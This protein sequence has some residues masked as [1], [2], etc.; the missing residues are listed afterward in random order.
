[1]ASWLK[2]VIARITGKSAQKFQLTRARA[3]FTHGAGSFDMEYPTNYPMDRYMNPDM[4]NGLIARL[5]SDG[6]FY[7]ERGSGKHSIDAELTVTGKPAAS[8]YELIKDKE[9]TSDG[10]AR[11]G[12]FTITFDEPEDGENNPFQYWVEVE[13][14]K[15]V[16]T[17]NRLTIEYVDPTYYMVFDQEADMTENLDEDYVRENYNRLVL[18][19]EKIIFEHIESEY[20]MFGFLIPREYGEISKLTG[21]EIITGDNNKWNYIPTFTKVGEVEV[22]GLMY[23]AYIIDTQAQYEEYTFSVKF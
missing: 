21:F 17:S 22:L 7:Y 5:T 13:N 6:P 23:D 10:K 4:G 11:E 20:Q 15:G 9:S 8:G 3:P 16:C 1:M 18:P 12:S 19:K 14:E 2:Q